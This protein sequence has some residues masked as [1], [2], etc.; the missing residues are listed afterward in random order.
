[1]QANTRNFIIGSGISGLIWKYFNPE[2]Q[3]ISPDVGAGMYTRT[4]MVWMHKTAETQYLMDQLKIPTVPKRSYI[5]YFYNGWISDFQTP[6]INHGIIQRKMTQWNE[7]V[8]GTFVPTSQD[9]SLTN[10]GQTNY[11]NTL[12]VNL[13]DVVNRVSLDSNPENGFVTKITDKTITVKKD[14]KSDEEMVYE[15]DN[16]VSTMA[17]PLFWKAYGQEKEFKSI[18]ITNIIV[19]KPP[20]EFDSLYEIVYYDKTFPFSRISHLQ[21]K[22][23]IEFTGIITRE[24]FEKL[25]P[26]LRVLDYFVVK[27]GRIWEC[28]NTPPHSNITFSGRFAQWQH[29]VVTESVI[30]Q[31][32]DYKNRK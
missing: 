25:Y 30:K 19:D 12:D 23:S 11:M 6:A 17:A 20:T 16:L 24:E 32:L 1:M 29:K 18:P 28:E 26:K 10:I 9:L 5:G 15:Y 2:F 4:F 7:E 8:K 31:A 27:Y 21:G 22:Y 14:F 3:I 13:V